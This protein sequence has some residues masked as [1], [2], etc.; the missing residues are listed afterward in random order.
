MTGLSSIVHTLAWAL[1][2]LAAMVGTYAVLVA[3]QV[4]PPAAWSPMGKAAEVS[5][6]APAPAEGVVSV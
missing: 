1:L 2:A 3:L 6:P 4:M 5:R